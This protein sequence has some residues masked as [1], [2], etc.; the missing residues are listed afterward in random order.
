MMTNLNAI[1]FVNVIDESHYK[2]VTE[3][4]RCSLWPCWRETGVKL[5]IIFGW[6]KWSELEEA[7]DSIWKVKNRVY[8]LY[9]NCEQH[10]DIHFYAKQN[11]DQKEAEDSVGSAGTQICDI[12]IYIYVHIYIYIYLKK[13]IHSKNAGLF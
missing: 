8:A 1:M 2:N 3:E 6:T 10:C 4:C 12:N 11:V 7:V 13:N 5:K 9:K